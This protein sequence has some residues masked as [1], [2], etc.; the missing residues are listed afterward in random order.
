MRNKKV[1][2]ITKEQHSGNTP[3]LSALTLNVN[4]LYFSMK[5]E[6]QVGLKRKI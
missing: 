3:Y 6:W 4:G 2:N 1:A 5:R